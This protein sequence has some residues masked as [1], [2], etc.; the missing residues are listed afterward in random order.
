M[1]LNGKRVFQDHQFPV[2]SFSVAERDRRWALVRTLMD[3]AG[4][5]ILVVPDEENSRYLTQMAYDIGPTILPLDGDVTA[6]TNHGRV[7]SAAATWLSDFRPFNRR[8]AAGI[9]ERL[10]E[11]DADRKIVGVVGLDGLMRRPD[12]DLNYNSFIW[13]REAFPHA[14]WVG[15]SEL[16]QEA[17]YVKSAEEIGFLTR[18]ARSTDA[19]LVAAAE[20]MRPGAVDREIW[21]QM[22]LAMAR[23]GGD[24]PRFAHL[25]IAPLHDTRGS[26]VRP[27]GHAATA[28]DI[29]FNEVDGRYAGYDAQGVQPIILGALPPD[30]AD[31]W[32][33]HLEAWER[34]WAVLRPGTTFSEVEA[35]VGPAAH[36]HIGVRQ[37]LH[38]RGLGD[39]MPLITSTSSRANRMGERVLEEGVGFVLKPYATWADERGPKELNWGDTV[40]VTR[41][42]ARRLGNRPHELIVKD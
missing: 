22:I 17:R 8:W 3:S 33:V 30:W 27:V 13:M 16:M 23:A 34:T 4:I 19:G 31:A 18:A 42:G 2:E 10:H 32:K 20:H 39:D 36:G 29:L 14:R 21:G 1:V 12:G 26:A 38:G 28:G 15:A 40:I 11:L 41:D 24:P 7:G 6:L 37:T 5:Q 9:V 35:A 25:G